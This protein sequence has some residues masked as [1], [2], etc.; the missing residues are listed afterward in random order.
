MRFTIQLRDRGTLTLPRALRQRYH[1][2][3][4]DVFTLVDVD[5]I[6]VLSPKTSLVAKL[7]AEIEQE[8]ERSGVS[9]AA[10]LQAAREERHGE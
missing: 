9:T 4:G 10:L 8:R 1:Y 6:L 3:P 7:A 2:G 5:G